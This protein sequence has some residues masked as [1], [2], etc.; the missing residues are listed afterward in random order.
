[1]AKDFARYLSQPKVNNEV[2]KGGLGRW[3]P[4][5]PEIAKMDAKFWLHAKNSYLPPYVQEGLLGPTQ[6]TWFSYNPAWAQVETQHIFQ[7]AMAGIWSG[8]LSPKQ[9]ADQAFAQ[10]EKIFAKYPIPTA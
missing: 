9:A 7:V 6:P 5:M 3:L 4:V 10:S 8:T 1:M 2:L